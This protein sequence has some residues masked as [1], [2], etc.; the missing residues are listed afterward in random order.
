M[1]C[2]VFTRGT[3]VYQL[4][5]LGQSLDDEAVKTLVESIRFAP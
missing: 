1:Q 2:F 5:A 4:S 3:V